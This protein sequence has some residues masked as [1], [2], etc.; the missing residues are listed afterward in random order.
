M[1]SYT[2]LGDLYLPDEHILSNLFDFYKDSCSE[3][4]ADTLEDIKKDQTKFDTMARRMLWFMKSEFKDVIMRS[5]IIL[6]ETLDA[7]PLVP[8]TTEMFLIQ[9]NITLL[10]N[11]WKENGKEPNLPITKRLSNFFYSVQREATKMWYKFMPSVMKHNNGD[12]TED[13]IN[14]N[15][16]SISLATGLSI[17]QVLAVGTTD[18]GFARSLMALHP[19]A[20]RII[21][22]NLALT[23]F[24]EIKKIRTYF[25][26]DD[27]MEAVEIFAESYGD[28]PRFLDELS[29]ICGKSILTEFDLIKPYREEIKDFAWEMRWAGFSLEGMGIKSMEDLVARLEPY[30]Y[31]ITR[32]TKVAAALNILA[33][34]V[35]LKPS[36]LQYPRQL[37]KL[38]EAFNEQ[39]M[40]N[41]MAFLKQEDMSGVIE[42]LKDD[43][44]MDKVYK[45]KPLLMQMPARLIANI[46]KISELDSKWLIFIDRNAKHRYSKMADI[47]L[48]KAL[49]LRSTKEY[50]VMSGH[51]RH[52]WVHEDIFRYD[53]CA[54]DMPNLDL[55]TIINLIKNQVYPTPYIL[56]TLKTNNM[57]V[58]Q[59]KETQNAYKKNKAFDIGNRLHQELEYFH[60][61]T[62]SQKMWRDTQDTGWY[63]SYLQRVTMLAE[64]GNKAVDEYDQNTI[65]QA[66]AESIKTKH[67]VEDLINQREQ[68]VLIT[69]NRSY[70][71]VITWAL[72]EGI[73]WHIF[74][75]L[76]IGS[77]VCHWQDEYTKIDLLSREQIKIL[78]KNNTDW[79][80]LDGT[81]GES[82]PDS[83]I[84]FRTY[85]NAINDALAECRNTQW[86]K[87]AIEKIYRSSNYENLKSYLIDII[88]ANKIDVN[89]VKPYKI[90]Y[91]STNALMKLRTRGQK[92][93]I[94]DINSEISDKYNYLFYIDPVI[95]WSEVQWA[96]DDTP[97]VSGLTLSYN[98]VWLWYIYR[99]LQEVMIQE[100]NKIITENETYYM[101]EAP[102]N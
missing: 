61:S 102:T 94:L 50:Q 71:K 8:T 16:N 44:C 43:D 86:E 36:I 87:Q 53:I 76:K 21:I 82:F 20:V 81:K 101:F 34:Y 15:A 91:I 69:P 13:R 3:Q 73:S 24:D 59:L 27:D 14:A 2:K 54:L 66:A 31:L 6:F 99:D 88:Q 60:Y 42:K 80:V 41:L 38:L 96:L 55:Q 32:E 57:T 22:F 18:E 11:W 65:K 23:D 63:Q 40:D 25:D 77:T 51:I 1:N 39:G 26:K 46:E 9:R 37:Y 58:P 95:R 84:G 75:P 29:H 4:I 85:M 90:K 68:H 79:Y 97:A 30:H 7:E 78:L 70:G 74:Q 17:E 64:H 100:A 47:V 5:R 67:I 83:N 19:D 12:I 33:K 28:I 48:E 52:A 45:M 35:P 72:G 92:W 10:T 49:P 98:E 93:V 62:T 56:D 89:M